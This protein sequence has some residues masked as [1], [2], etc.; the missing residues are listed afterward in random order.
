MTTGRIR[1]YAVLSAVLAVAL[2]GCLPMSP[3]IR[4]DINDL[5]QSSYQARKDIA[6]NKKAIEQIQSTQL[7][8]PK[9]QSL[10]AIR[11]SQTTLYGRVNDLHEEVQA[12][13][14]KMEVDMH[15]AQTLT[16]DTAAQLDVIKATSGG[17][18][19]KTDP[20]IM[21][22]LARLENEIALI[23]K[24]LSIREGAA[25]GGAAPTDPVVKDSPEDAYKAAYNVFKKKKYTKAR[26]MFEAFIKANA[27][28]KLAGN[29]VFWV[30]ETY[31]NEGVYDNA[32]LSYDDLIRKYPGSNKVPD[33]MLKQGYAFI[34]LGDPL[35]AKGLLKKIVLNFPGSKAA[36]HARAKLK[37]LD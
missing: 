37:T 8:I 13:I 2:S 25:T 16:R 22:R 19:A 6:M 7:E 23:K 15:K 27:S 24:K 12:L 5:K 34:K 30:G 1:I 10:T 20:A 11:E 14:G 21:D 26:E 28:H 29:A 4:R 17:G 33:A 35:A 31:Y 3:D 18:G 36:G 32:I 9:E